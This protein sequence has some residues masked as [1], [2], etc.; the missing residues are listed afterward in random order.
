LGSSKIKTQSNPEEQGST[1]ETS[2]FQVVVR[3]S[4]LLAKRLTTSKNLIPLP[5]INHIGHGSGCLCSLWQEI[6]PE[7]SRS[8]G[9]AAD[10]W[11][12]VLY[13]RSGLYIVRV[14][15]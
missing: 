1:I 11:Q 10:D 3:G 2:Q 15:V 6:Y 7:K 14:L 4:Q 13:T 5:A 12:F 8:R 9:I